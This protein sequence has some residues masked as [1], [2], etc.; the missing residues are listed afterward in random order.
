MKK[1]VALCAISSI[2]ALV[3]FSCR[4]EPVLPGHEVSFSQEIMPI[5]QLS[6]QHAG[7]HGDTL[8]EQPKLVDYE[9]VIS[10]GDVKAGDPKHSKLYDVITTANEEDK[11]PPAP[12]TL[13]ERNVKLIY[14]WI[15]QGAKN[16]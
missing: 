5:I 14:I 7:C 2:P 3:F 11:M 1:L 16:N 13:S 6:C 9:S 4:H 10:V 15:A 12:Y 8:N